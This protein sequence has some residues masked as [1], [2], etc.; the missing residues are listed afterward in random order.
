[1]VGDERLESH[2]R[3]KALILLTLR[4]NIARLYNTN[5]IQVQYIEA[6]NGGKVTDSRPSKTHDRLRP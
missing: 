6:R 1:M 5:P 2:L 3:D 4:L